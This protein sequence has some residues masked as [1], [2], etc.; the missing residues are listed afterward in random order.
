MLALGLTGHVRVLFGQASPLSSLARSCVPLSAATYAATS[1]G[2]RSRSPS[3]RQPLC[4]PD[5]AVCHVSVH[6]LGAGCRC[7]AAD[8]SCRATAAAALSPR[9]VDGRPLRWL[10]S[11][12]LWRAQVQFAEVGDALKR[13][14]SHEV[15]GSSRAT[16]RHRPGVVDR[17][18]VLT[19][20]SPRARRV[21]TASSPLT[22]RILTASSPRPHRML[23]AS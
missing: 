3:T 18:R 2:C 6:G 21:L 12:S 8:R 14:L 19:L 16:W 23:A 22:R 10:L 20:S 7:R 9:L 15:R 5:R 13:S 4:R 11:H 1:P 17:C